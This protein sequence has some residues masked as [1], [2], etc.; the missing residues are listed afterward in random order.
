MPMI[1][2]LMIDDVKLVFVLPVLTTSIHRGMCHLLNLHLLFID[3]RKHLIVLT[4]SLWKSL[5]GV[6]E[7]IITMIKASYSGARMRAA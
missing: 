7:K 2:S 6:P 4:G 3:L 1:S 5:R